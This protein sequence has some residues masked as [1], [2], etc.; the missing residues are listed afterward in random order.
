MKQVDPLVL[1]FV[2]KIGRDDE[3]RDQFDAIWPVE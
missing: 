3:S 1:S 2:D